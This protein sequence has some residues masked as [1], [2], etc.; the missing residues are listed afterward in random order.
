M[1]KNTNIP[2]RTKSTEIKTNEQEPSLSDR[3]STL[4]RHVGQSEEYRTLRSQK[5]THP[6]AY[7]GAVSAILTSPENGFNNID[8]ALLRTSAVLGSYIEAQ[9]ELSALEDGPREHGRLP[10]ADFD[11]TKELKRSYVIP[12]NHELKSL[13]DTIPNE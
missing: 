5:V 6:D 13:I 1:T 10:Q 3:L 9:E 2:Y 11:R 12:F 4:V 7:Q 8:S